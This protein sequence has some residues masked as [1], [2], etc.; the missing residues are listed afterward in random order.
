M[1][2]LPLLQFGYYGRSGAGLL[3]IIILGIGTGL[4]CLRAL[5]SREGMYDRESA[6]IMFWSNWVG[7]ILGFGVAA[8]GLYLLGYR[9][10]H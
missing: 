8:A 9:F 3:L 6:T 1:L 4:G 5:A 2:P 10:W 7:V